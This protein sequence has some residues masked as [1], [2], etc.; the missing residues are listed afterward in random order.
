MNMLSNRGNCLKSNILNKKTRRFS[1]V[2][3]N[4][5]ELVNNYSV[6]DDK[7]YFTNFLSDTG[8][9]TIKEKF[10]K[11]YNDIIVSPKNIDSYFEGTELYSGVSNKRLANIMNL[12]NMNLIEEDILNIL[13]YKSRDDKGFQLFIT[14]DNNVLKIILID[15]FHLGIPSEYQILKSGQ[16]IKSNP[17][18]LYQKN[19]DNKY[20]LSQLIGVATSV[21]KS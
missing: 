21:K 15:F 2:E 5:I 18:R 1:E 16:K 19:S 9:N 4:K 11:V 6:K 13:K 12:Y 3:Y 7:L 8:H 17:Q 20:C 10:K 14:K